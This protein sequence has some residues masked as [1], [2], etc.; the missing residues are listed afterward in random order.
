MKRVITLALLAFALA[1]FTPGQDVGKTS[2]G[3]DGKQIFLQATASPASLDFGDQVIETTSKPL[4]VTLTNNLDKPI[5]IRSVD[6]SQ[7]GADFV[8]DDDY[9]FIDMAIEPG[10]SCSIGVVF[11]PLLVG[12]RSAFLLITYN[13]PD[14]PQKI[15]LK[16]N[17]IE[18]S[19]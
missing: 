11:F 6:M 13:D 9:E 8:A 17:G 2:Q 16:G 10:K 12:E 7:D 3:K 19:I 5:K 14:H 4:R 1:T 15:S 18:P